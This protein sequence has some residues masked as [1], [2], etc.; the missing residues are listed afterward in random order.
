MVVVG[1]VRGWT[2]DAIEC[3]L[4]APRPGMPAESYKRGHAAGVGVRSYAA[5][6]VA[7]SVC[8]QVHNATERSLVEASPGRLLG[9]R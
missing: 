9:G 2:H 4:V 1:A 7:W 3:A 8:G 6:V 5:V